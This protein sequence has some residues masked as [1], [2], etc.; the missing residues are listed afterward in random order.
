MS[1]NRR[2]FI[3]FVSLGCITPALTVLNG[4]THQKF[5][6]PDQDIL[7]GGGKFKKN[8][9]LHHVLAVVNLPQKETQLVDLDFLAHGIIIDPGDKKRLITFEK[10]GYGAA[11]I[12]LNDHT[13][14]AKIATSSDKYFNGHG[15]FNASGDT[16]FCTETYL[17]NH[18]GI[19]AI[20][21]GKNLETLGE[22]PAYGEN[23]HECK[24][25]DDGAILVVTNAGSASIDKSQPSVTYIDVQTQQLIERVTL[26]NKQ[27]NTG[28]IGIATDGSLI[29]ASAPREGLEQTHT[30]G[31]S[32]RSG[33]QA[34]LSMTR[35]EMVIR[36]IKGEALSVAIDNKHKIAAV[37]HPDGNLVTFWSIDKRELL[38]AVSVPQ[39]RGVTL[40][41]DEKSFIFSYD[42]N[43][44]MVL[45]STRD[46]TANPDS[47]MQPTYISGSHI[48]NWS[49]TL[50]EIMPADVYS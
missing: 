25:I 7:L 1:L 40:S 38:K 9:V 18:N 21:S 31:V 20:R 19:V 33:K 16:F 24:L 27:L 15:A 49:K 45:F 41:L 2:N 14:T 32:I 36:Q 50:T 44:S 12:N 5:Y 35:P 29:V 3:K 39:P 37:T 30:G 47:I 4:C 48:I 42:F 11:E 43:T 10:N 22:F 13:V 46:L 28:H 26:T 6:N 34:M 23:P 8:D 17:N